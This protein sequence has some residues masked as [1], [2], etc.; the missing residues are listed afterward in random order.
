MAADGNGCDRRHRHVRRGAGLRHA[1]DPARA[2]TKATPPVASARAYLRGGLPAIYQDGDFGMRFVGALEKLLDPIV[3]RPRRAARA[4]RPRPRAARHAR[5]CWRR[6][7]A[8]SSTSRRTG[9]HQREMVRR[10]GRARPP[11]RH[12]S[13][14]SSWRSQLHFPDLPL[15]VEDDGGVRWYARRRRAPA[16]APPPRFV[17]Y[18]DTPVA[19]TTQAAI[20]RC[21]EQLQAGARRRTGCA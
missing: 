12:A 2:G 15:R 1:A 3:A 17:V 6:G 21:I 16:E 19:E 13:A 8:S 11:A 18:C 7:S 5:A 4:L 10:C 14:A 9:D 20:A